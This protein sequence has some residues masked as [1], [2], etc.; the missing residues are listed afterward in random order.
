MYSHLSEEAIE[1]AP[2]GSI[3]FISK[4]SAA[5]FGPFPPLIA[6]TRITFCPTRRAEIASKLSRLSQA[7]SWAINRSLIQSRY[8]LSQVI[9]PKA[10][11]GSASSVKLFLKAI[12]SPAGGTLGDRAVSDQIHTPCGS[13]ALGC[14]TSISMGLPR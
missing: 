9:T 14:A 13:V 6:S 1:T 7:L 4:Y 8:S 5:G 3:S 2:R 12:F 11:F 10:W